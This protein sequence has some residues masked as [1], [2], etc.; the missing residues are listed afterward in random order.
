MKE[1]TPPAT[2][3]ALTHNDLVERLIEE[4]AEIIKAAQKCKIFGFDRSYGDYGHN[5]AVLAFE[6]GDAAAIMDA[7]LSFHPELATPFAEARKSK[8]ARALRAKAD[9]LEELERERNARPQQS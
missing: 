1:Q 6:M 9:L 4:C 2:I 8:I 5:G 7:L 3:I